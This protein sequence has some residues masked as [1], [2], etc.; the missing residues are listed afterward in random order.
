MYISRIELQNWKNFKS[1]SAHLARRVFVI[2]PNASGKSN[3]LDAFRFLRDLAD[4]GLNQAV[5]MR[6]GVKPLRCLAA[7]ESPG[8]AIDVT[9]SDNEGNERWQY[10][11]EFN[12]DAN[13]IPRIRQELVRDLRAKKNDVIRRPDNKDKEDPVLLTQ[14]ALEQIVANR[15][16]REVAEF[17]GSISYQHIVPQVV[18][19]PK[20]FS[21]APVQNDPFGRDLLPRLWNTAPVTRKAW[22][23]RISKVLQQAVPQLKS[24]EV[25]M[26]AQGAPHLIGRYEHWRVHDARQ[27]ESQF[28]DGT[29]RLFGLMWAMFEGNGPLLLEEPELSLHPEV[30]RSLPQM[31][32]KLQE[33]IRRMKR[34][35]GYEPR[36]ILISTHSEEMLRDGGIGAEEVLRIEPSSEGSIIVGPN[37]EDIVALKAGLT[38]ADVILPKS[39]PKKG[40]LVLDF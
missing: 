1:T 4:K 28:S 27:N 20:G 11:I 3:L 21:P 25:E 24:L 32:K 14:T 8:I 37:A 7:R 29:L 36:Q 34:K 10:R 2:G 22:L 23:R 6:G 31:L 40:Q 9:L 19:D 17:F 12:Q 38:V 18:R 26:D 16:F 15:K 39:A 35:G 13:R 33:E 30:V 5:G